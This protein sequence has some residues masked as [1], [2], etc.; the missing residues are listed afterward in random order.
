MLKYKIKQLIHHREKNKTKKKNKNNF[1]PALFI[2]MGYSVPVHCKIKPG[3][4]K[5]IPHESPYENIAP[6]AIKL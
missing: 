1:C 5:K 2:R 3:Q 6:Y 4:Q